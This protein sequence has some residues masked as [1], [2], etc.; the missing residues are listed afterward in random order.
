MGRNP[1]VVNP[2][3]ATLP[4]DVRSKYWHPGFRAI[5]IRPRTKDEDELGAKLPSLVPV[6]T[7]IEHAL[8]MLLRT[9]KKKP[10]TVQSSTAM[11]VINCAT[12]NT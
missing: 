8:W 9:P 5:C 6:W 12:V 3:A 2:D 10:F 1:T 7:R 11:P 4:N